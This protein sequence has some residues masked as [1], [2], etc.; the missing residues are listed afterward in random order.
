[1]EL[2]AEH[3]PVEP[4]EARTWLNREEA[5]DRKNARVIDK[6]RLALPRE[7]DEEQR[8]KLVVDFARDLTQNRTPWYAAIHQSGKD[9]HNPHCHLVIRDRDIESGKRVIKL[10][11]SAR[12]RAKVGLQGS[13]ADMVRERWETYANRA[14][15]RAGHEMRIDRRSLEAQG[16][17]REPTIHIGPRA[18]HIEKTVKRPESQPRKNGRG[19]EIDYP[20]ID[21]GRTR[22]ERNAQIVNL[23]LERDIR[24]PDFATRERAK[25]LRNEIQRDD[26]LEGQLIED[27]RRRTEKERRAMA[28]HRKRMRVT[29]AHWLEE[30]AEARQQLGSDA[31]MAK[32]ALKTRQDAAKAALN[33][34][35][36]KLS[37]RVLRF[38]D[39][40]GGTRRQ[41]NQARRDLQRKHVAERKAL[42]DQLRETKR[43]QLEAIDARQQAVMD[44]V[45]RAANRTRAEHRETRREADRVADQRRQSRAAERTRSEAVFEK[46]LKM[47]EK[48]RSVGVEREGPGRDIG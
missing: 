10:S 8:A 32:L 7:L 48:S 13:A 44:E 23:N 14:L 15:E 35:Q 34:R 3:M 9:A 42:R 46:A 5:A 25:F 16:I 40:T 39:I 33:E 37:A 31:F 36:G 2:I 24:S 28:E 17:D 18:Q 12:D 26:A 38:V 29:R 6:I 11:D 27:A 4:Q 22:M 19:R 43:I 21:A 47:V 30:Q 1:P 20:L 41:Q 45:K